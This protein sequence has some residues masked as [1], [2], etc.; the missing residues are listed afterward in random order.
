MQNITHFHG[1]IV[2]TVEDGKYRCAT[3]D[4]QVTINDIC[5]KCIC[6]A[7]KEKEHD[8]MLNRIA[9][10]EHR[11]EKLY[12]YI[13]KTAPRGT[14]RP[15]WRTDEEMKLIIKHNYRFRKDEYSYDSD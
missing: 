14:S 12:N 5:E 1:E 2:E 6:K 9:Y 15:I 13:S 4:N 11:L 3:C 8:M 7:E 10:L